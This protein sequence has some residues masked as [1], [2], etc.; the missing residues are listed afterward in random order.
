[1]KTPIVQT[2]LN[3]NGRCEEA[4]EFYRQALGAEV[5]MI[6][7]FKDAPPSDGCPSDGGG[8]I[9]PEKIMHSSFRI[10]STTVMASD[11]ACDDDKS[12][13]GFSLSLTVA[14]EAEADLYFAA[15][16]EAGKVGMPLGKT[17]WSPRFG[18][19]EDRFGVNW[20]ISVISP[21][22]EPPAA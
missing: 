19:V 4:V 1:M 22:F 16:S 12:F 20:M 10:G 18:V 21:E 17:F 9:T 8:N 14:T 13:K 11:C 15:L 6:L 2:Y 7:R 5:D 3:F